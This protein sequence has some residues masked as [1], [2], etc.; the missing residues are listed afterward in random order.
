MYLCD[1]NAKCYYNNGNDVIRI[2]RNDNLT[3]I[4]FEISSHKYIFLYT[5]I[6]LREIYYAK[7]NNII[8][9]VMIKAF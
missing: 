7:R 1:I 2:N 4:T 8:I 6:I 3:N 5:N 9:T